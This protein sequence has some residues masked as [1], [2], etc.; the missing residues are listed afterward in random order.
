M[1]IQVVGLVTGEQLIAK[2]E[3]KENGLLLK[4]AAI[5]L[6]A[7][8]GELGMAPWIPYCETDNGVL[9]KTNTIAWSVSAKTDLANHYNTAFG[10]G[11]VV[12]APQE[13]VAPEL[14]LVEG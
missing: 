11:L 7:G 3:E 2:V 14:K 9:V 13:V 6:P 12:P 1:N 10:N 8:K 4:N 5:L